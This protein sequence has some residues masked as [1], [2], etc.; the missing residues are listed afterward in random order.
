MKVKYKCTHDKYNDL[1]QNI[2]HYFN[3]NRTLIWDRR[4]K[5]K[6]L[7]FQ[8]EQIVVK[9]FKI[10][11]LINRIAYSFF[12]DAKAQKSYENSLKISEFVPKAIAYA[13]FKKFGLYYDSYFLCEEYVY[14]LTIREPLIEDDFKDKELI[15]K[16]FALFT[17]SLHEK[18]VH[19]LDY[20][21]GNILIKKVADGYE[22]KIIDINR[23][24][25]KVLSSQERIENFSKLWATDSDLI[26]IIKAYANYANMDEKKAIQIA[27][28]ASHVHKKKKNFKKRLKGKKVVD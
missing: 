19:H 6:V 3:A 2:R 28:D 17:Y 12:R 16:A 27:L 7:P 15:L 18:G 20:S 1:V 9:S 10:P 26:T 5:I 25:F 23:M 24:Q 4:N 14:D 13:A 8:E 11:H 22:F 21:P